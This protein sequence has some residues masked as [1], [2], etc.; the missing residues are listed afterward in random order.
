MGDPKLSILEAGPPDRSQ[1]TRLPNVAARLI[2]LTGHHQMRGDWRPSAADQTIS[3]ALNDAKAAIILAPVMIE[4]LDGSHSSSLATVAVDKGQILAVALE[5]APGRQISDAKG[6]AGSAGWVG[7]VLHVTPF[8]AEGKM[9][10]N[11]ARKIEDLGEAAGASRKDAARLE[12]FFE[13]TDGW[14]FRSL[15]PLASH[16]L[17]FISR[18]HVTQAHVIGHEAAAGS[19]LADLF[20]GIA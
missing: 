11:L 15:S 16:A 12:R 10:W 17:L 5:S 13:L 6:I 14:L 3:E 2:V 8:I 18:D 4:E 1:V 20:S 7:A 9:R 19:H